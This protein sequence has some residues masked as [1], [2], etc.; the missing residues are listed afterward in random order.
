MEDS[1][2]TVFTCHKVQFRRMKL[3][4]QKIAGIIGPG[5]L[6]P[7]GLTLEH[8]APGNED[9]LAWKCTKGR[10]KTI[11]PRPNKSGLT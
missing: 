1:K 9:E 10:R 4:D 7:E 2:K 11:R 6:N 8:L 3:V 5:Q